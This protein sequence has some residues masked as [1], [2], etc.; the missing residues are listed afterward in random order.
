[1]SGMG[2]IKQ[3]QFKALKVHK[4][5]LSYVALDYKLKIIENYI[6]YKRLPW[7][8]SLVKQNILWRALSNTSFWKT[9]K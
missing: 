7:Y 5:F 1:M 6:N 3:S 2:E 8:I 9:S 4:S